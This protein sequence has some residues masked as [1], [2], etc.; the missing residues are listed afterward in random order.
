MQTWENIVSHWL[1]EFC[2]G[3]TLSTVLGTRNYACLQKVLISVENYSK[4]EDNNTPKTH[5]Y[6]PYL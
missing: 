3:P 1:N 2:F 6:M 5:R 4:H